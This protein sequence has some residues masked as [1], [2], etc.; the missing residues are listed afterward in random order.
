MPHRIFA[1]FL[2]V[3]IAF[4]TVHASSWWE[5]YSAQYSNVS[6]ENV[7]AR[8]KYHSAIR[9]QA[10][11]T[12]EVLKAIKTPVKK[13][14]S[15]KTTKTWQE[16]L[17]KVVNTKK[18]VK[19]PIEKYTLIV[20]P[21][22]DDEI[23][24]CTS[25]IRDLVEQDKPLKI[26]YLTD[27]D[28]KTDLDPIASQSYAQVRRGESTL[29]TKQLGV[30]PADLIWLGFP[31][32]I[33]GNLREEVIVSPFTLRKTTSDN[34]YRPGLE[35]TRENLDTVLSD[36]MATYPPVAIYFPDENEERH[37]DHITA[38]RVVW[39]LIK[40]NPDAQHHYRYVI[41]GN[42]EPK[43]S[44]AY[45]RIKASLIGFFQSQFHDS[46]HKEFLESFAYKA[47]TFE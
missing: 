21:H 38:G 23:L 25:V 3:I 5:A 36:I 13:T 4:S 16:R 1:L 19:K 6:A 31:D 45:D 8:L 14:T 24:C 35:Y 30:D 27:G 22:P 46:G 34:S 11:E 17:K 18:T 47:E 40:A 10:R 20:A 39:D 44:V 2:G 32:A 7:D 33:L 26:I 12:N 15:K 28:A 42:K 43:E 37:P 41:H 9:Q 29:A